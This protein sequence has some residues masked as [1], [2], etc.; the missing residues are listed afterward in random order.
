MLLLLVALAVP[1][2][3]LETWNYDTTVIREI[4][5]WRYSAQFEPA[6][7]PPD[8]PWEQLAVVTLPWSVERTNPMA[9][10]MAEVTI[11]AVWEELDVLIHIEGHDSMALQ[12][13]GA[14]VASMKAP[15][16]GRLTARL[17]EGIHGGDTATLAIGCAHGEGQAQLT[18]V[19]LESEPAGLT[20]AVSDANTALD[21]LTDYGKPVHPWKRLVEGPDD[22]FEVNFDDSEWESVQVGDTWRGDYIP[23]WY[24]GQLT[25]PANV[26]GVSTREETPLLALD[27]DDPAECYFN[28]ELVEPVEKD[29][30]GSVF[31][32][33]EGTGPGDTI[34]VAFRIMNRW[35]TGKLRQAS[36]RLASIDEGLHRKRDLQ[37]E[38]NRLARTI[39]AHD[40]PNEAWVE[41]IEDLVEP[42][43]AAQAEWST[44]TEH[45]TAA[46]AAFDALLD[47]VASD[48]VLLVPPYLQDVRTD[49]ITVCFETSAPVPAR[50]DFGT[51]DLDQTVEESERS[52]AIHKITLAD[53]KPDTTYHYRV[54]AGR[55]QTGVQSFT[56]APDTTAPF[57]FLVF[58]DNQS[59]FRMFE[60]VA[61]QMGA[62]SADFV[63]S[64]GDVVDRGINWDEWTQQ[65]LL[66]ARHFMGKKPSF[67]AMGN[68]EYGGYDG[69]P[70]VA[71]FDYY[72]KHPQTSP[73]SNHYWYAF[74][75]AN[76]RF[77]V[78]EPLKMEWMDHPDPERG[79]T[80]VPDDPQLVW[81]E[82]ELKA[83]RDN[84]DWTFVFYHEPAYLETWSGGYH[85]G[86]DFLRNAV[87][88]IL[89][90]YDVDMVFNG[91]TH[92]YERGLPHPE[93]DPVARTGNGITYIITGG[94]GGSLD[95]HK[96]KEWDK[97]DLPDHPARPDSDE[98]DEGEYYR[99]HFCELKVDGKT[100]TFKAR[101]VLENGRLGRVLDDF[102]LKK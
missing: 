17:P 71:A 74:T 89:E 90:E 77:V 97:I 49:Q 95:D 58:G 76:A 93:W 18:R 79:N 67:I 73:G 27:F 57:H 35:G 12:V 19:W 91:H 21:A 82:Q 2:G 59:G 75:Y 8:T 45:V 42:L 3:A 26:A 29:F 64:V 32:L 46:R 38:L 50:V 44:F 85:D 68:H 65:Y 99:H 101:E 80:I 100:V 36:W 63:M 1:A 60:R 40:Q 62:T 96:Y 15:G 98:P 41:Q 66:P 47:E 22:A 48:P 28:G 13:N 9:W 53:L 25:V 92:A 30:R 37:V 55:Q 31:A 5:D 24:R 81:L 70:N 78:L 20:Q 87:V 86:E 39:R 83:N 94:A 43:E 33:P 23:A 10:F 11:P 6:D 54:T 88:P 56:T 4:R 16:P 34:A 102:K 52:E 7:A 84:H 61:R 69:N 51:G 14:E 72:F